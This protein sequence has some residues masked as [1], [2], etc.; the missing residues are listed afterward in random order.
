LNK[1]L[2]SR[3]YLEPDFSNFSIE[4]IRSKFLYDL[5]LY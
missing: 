5:K 1:L 3:S 4:K 2:I